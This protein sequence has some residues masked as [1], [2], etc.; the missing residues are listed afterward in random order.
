[1]TSF[2]QTWDQELLAYCNYSELDCCLS[3]RRV[4]AVQRNNVEDRNAFGPDSSQLDNPLWG[5][6]INHN[7]VYYETQKIVNTRNTY[8][9]LLC[10]EE[11]SQFG[12][13]QTTDI[14]EVVFSLCFKMSFGNEFVL[15]DNEHARN[16]ISKWKAVHLMTCFEKKVKTD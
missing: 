12:S 4:C 16:L 1:M 14:S 5:S 15:R 11:K 9:M 10:S 7:K 6:K 2:P 13:L 3:C 8:E